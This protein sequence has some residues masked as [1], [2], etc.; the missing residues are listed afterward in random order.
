MINIILL[1]II[2]SSK[3]D[4]N[5]DLSY[6]VNIFVI[7]AVKALSSIKRSLIIFSSYTNT[8]IST[9]WKLYTETYFPYIHYHS[10]T[11]QLFAAFF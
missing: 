6:V 11:L 8:V 4:R 5:L 2:I 10:K 1:I 3:I 9:F 7:S